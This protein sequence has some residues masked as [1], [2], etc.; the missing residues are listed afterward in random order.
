MPS[1]VF[2]SI[3]L[4]VQAET[5]KAWVH[6]GFWSPTEVVTRMDL[7]LFRAPA[8][9]YTTSNK[10]QSSDRPGRVTLSV[11]RNQTLHFTQLEFQGD[12]SLNPVELQ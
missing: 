4:R 2:V 12:R 1:N 7:E 8:L 3:V 9:G 5:G 6:M 10:V 11:N